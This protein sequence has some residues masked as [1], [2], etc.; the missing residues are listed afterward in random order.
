[1]ECFFCIFEDV[2]KFFKLLDLFCDV[3]LIVEEE[4]SKEVF[5]G[6]LD[7][8]NGK[9]SGGYYSYEVIVRIFFSW[10]FWDVE[11]IIEVVLGVLVELVLELY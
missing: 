11:R 2:D 9:V 5:D 8:F 3:V 4:W 10:K 7:I 1:M 6:L